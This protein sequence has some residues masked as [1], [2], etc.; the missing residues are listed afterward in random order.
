MRKVCRRSLSGR[1]RQTLETVEG[2]GIT[3]YRPL[4]Q[5]ELAACEIRDH[6]GPEPPCGRVRIQMENLPLTGELAQEGGN[7]K[8][9]DT[10]ATETPTDK[11]VA[12]VVFGTLEVGVAVHAHETGKLTVDSDQKRPGRGGAPITRFGLDVEKTMFTQFQ[13]QPFAEVLH[14]ELHQIFDGVQFVA[15]C[16]VQF[17]RRHVGAL[18]VEQ[19]C[20]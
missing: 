17:Y 11:E 7:D 20:P 16:G 18:Q 4:M 1:R 12:D 3:V 5:G 8:L 19:G 10:L 15:L 6:F 14:I 2:A 13:W 9:R